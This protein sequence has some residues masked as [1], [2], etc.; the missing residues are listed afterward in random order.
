M[1]NH[2]RSLAAAL[3]VVTVLSTACSSS[4]GPVQPTSAQLQDV[5]RVALVLDAPSEF[6][7]VK[8]QTSDRSGRP[9]VIVGGLLFGALGA[10]L[11]MAANKASDGNKDRASAEA[12]KPGLTAS[13]AILRDTLRQALQASGR[14]AAIETPPAAPEGSAARAYDA[15]L[16]VRVPTWGLLVAQ[17]EPPLLTSFAEV[18]A[19]LT[20][21]RTGEVLWQSS[22]NRFLGTA[23]QPLDAYRRDA[24]LTRQELTESFETAGRFLAKELTSSATD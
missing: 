24:E 4:R 5:R 17:R 12:L 7:I 22:V 3:L 10:G 14:F 11:A 2:L 6:Q 19:K 9:G 13:P 16:V 15:I 8:E 20:R 23:Q 18:E 21:V 1:T